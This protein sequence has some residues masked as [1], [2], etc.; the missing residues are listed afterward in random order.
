M[1]PQEIIDKVAAFEQDLAAFYERIE[2]EDRFK[3][4]RKVLQYMHKHSAIHAQLIRN[5]RPEAGLPQLSIEPLQALHARI[6]SV[7]YQQLMATEDLSQVCDQLAQSEALVGKAYAVIAAHFQ[8]LS[9]VY[10]K[11]SH[12]FNALADDE[13]QHH[14]ELLKQ[15]P[16]T[17]QDPSFYR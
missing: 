2:T 7:L 8:K 10:S 9:D 6:K 14:D 15:A 12:K 1:H 11:L 5:Y 17:P 13:M 16:G 3:R 4:M